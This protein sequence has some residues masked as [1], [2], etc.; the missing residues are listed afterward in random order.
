MSTKCLPK[1][2]RKGLGRNGL[3]KVLRLMST[4]MSTMV[5]FGS[6][7]QGFPDPFLPF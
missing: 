6:G 4:K 3:W 2:T 1:N 5:T 7:K